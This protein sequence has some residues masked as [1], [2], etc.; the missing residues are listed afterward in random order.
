MVEIPKCGHTGG[1]DIEGRP[2]FIVMGRK[3][4]NWC[5]RLAG[6]G[7]NTGVFQNMWGAIKRAFG[8]S[9]ESTPTSPLTDLGHFEVT[10]RRSPEARAEIDRLMRELEEER[11]V[12]EAAQADAQRATEAERRARLELEA[13]KP[14]VEESEGADVQE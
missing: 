10:D 5:P 11:A 14:K 7:I 12:R 8:V 6:M 1:P 13:I 4:P 3:P 9:S 2:G